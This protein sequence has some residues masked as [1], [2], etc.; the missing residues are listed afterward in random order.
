MICNHISVS[1]TE[2]GVTVIPFITTSRTA[3]A[4][5]VFSARSDVKPAVL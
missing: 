5:G 4:V 2:T 1:I 3:R